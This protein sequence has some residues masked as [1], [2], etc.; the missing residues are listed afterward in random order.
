M[1]GMASMLD[2]AQQQQKITDDI[3]EE[4][5]ER[6]ENKF[7]GSIKPKKGHRLYKYN[8]STHKLFELTDEDYFD[9]EYHVDQK[10][11]PYSLVD[12]DGNP[13]KSF[14]EHNGKFLKRENK[15]TGTHKRK[16]KVELN[17]YYFSAL[18]ETNAINTIKK[19]FKK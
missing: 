10:F 13:V 17:T 16:I 7:F 4:R 11:K 2:P 3:R 19:L 6:L 9:P 14:R 18:N 1:I 15:V 8:F 12:K 5:Q